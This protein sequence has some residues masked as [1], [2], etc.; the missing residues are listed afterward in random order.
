VLEK[1]Q[2]IQA[3]A[4]RLVRLDAPLSLPTARYSREWFRLTDDIKTFIAW[5]EARAGDAFTL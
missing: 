2:A 3:L 4:D 5:A 1:E